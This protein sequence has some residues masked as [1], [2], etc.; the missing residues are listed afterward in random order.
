MRTAR[1]NGSTPTSRSS[2]YNTR[3][4]IVGWGFFAEPMNASGRQAFHRLAAGLRADG[5]RLLGRMARPW[6]PV[7]RRARRS[8]CVLVPAWSVSGSAGPTTSCRP[9]R[10]W[11]SKQRRVRTSRS[12]RVG[13]FSAGVDWWLRDRLIVLGRRFCYK[14]YGMCPL[15]RSRTEIMLAC[16]GNDYGVVGNEGAGLLQ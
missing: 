8:P 3:L 2:D 5:V 9:I 14:R 13:D 1:C 7:S 6:N 10:R 12:T 11:D 4:G 16:K 15:G